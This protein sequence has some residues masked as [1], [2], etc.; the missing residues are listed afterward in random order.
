M[1]DEAHLRASLNALRWGVVTERLAAGT[2]DWST[3]HTHEVGERAPGR[4]RF[5]IVAVY[6][7]GNAPKQ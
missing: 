5:E 1:A 2:S 6:T 4:D 3:C 7:I